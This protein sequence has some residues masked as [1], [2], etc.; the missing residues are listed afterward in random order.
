MIYTDQLN[1]KIEV[2]E[3][4]KRIISLVPSQT[5]LLVTLGLEDAIVGITKFCVHPKWLRKEKT[6]VGGTK[7]VNY[8]KIR[9]LNPD[10]ILCNKEENTKEIVENLEKEY[11]VHVSDIFSVEDATNMIQQYGEIFKM[12]NEVNK[13][14]SKIEAEQRLFK[15]QVANNP[16]KKVGY[17][18]WKDPW[19]AVG[20]NTFIDHL[21]ELNNFENVFASKNRYPEVSLE[22]INALGE[23]DLI[24]LSSEPFP[25]SEK[26]I[27]EI[28]KINQRAKVLL[29]DGEYFSWYGSRLADA[30]SY[31]KTLHKQNIR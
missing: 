12:E 30:F 9:K 14:V 15:K 29:V 23:Q 16:K 27:L 21:L 3:A 6:I 18:I 8:D 25:F 11:A 7:K 1:R 13:L 22:E 24:L 2:F 20:A 10:I 28:Q 31:F 17:F 5:E 19:I 4:P 26:H